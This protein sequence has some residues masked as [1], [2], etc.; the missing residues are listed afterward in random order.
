MRWDEA[1]GNRSGVIGTNQHNQGSPKRSWWSKSKGDEE[2]LSRWDLALGTDNDTRIMYQKEPK[3]E[4]YFGHVMPW[5]F[6]DVNYAEDP[7]DW[8]LT[9]GFTFMLAG[10]PIAWKLKK[11]ASVALSTTEAEYYTLGIAC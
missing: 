2:G 10:G 5:P 7:K 1:Q 3:S 4:V 11:K 6:C 8:K 9:S